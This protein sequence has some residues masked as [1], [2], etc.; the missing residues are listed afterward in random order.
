MQRVYRILIVVILVLAIAI[1]FL[2]YFGF[3]GTI[4]L[5]KVAD[6]AVVGFLDS[7]VSLFEGE[8]AYTNMLFMAVIGI[9][10][11]LLVGAIM[12]KFITG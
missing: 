7:I 3:H 6:G 12:Y 9:G 11:V 10:M 1:V 4:I 8:N 2:D 5:D